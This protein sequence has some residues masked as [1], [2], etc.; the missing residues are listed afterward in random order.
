MQNLSDIT[1]VILAGGLGTRLQSIMHDRPKALAEVRGRAFL[2]YILD[3]IANIGV[4]SVV[5]CTGYMG[6]QVRSTFGDSYKRI[7]LIYS[8]ELSPLGTA[9]ALRFAM[10]LFKSNP[11]L[12]MNGDS[13]CLADLRLFWDWHHAKGAEASLLL[14]H[15]PDIQRY[16]QIQINEEN[17]VLRF[18]E[19]GLKSGQGWINAGIYIIA[20]SLIENIPT[21]CVV[22]LEQDMFPMWVG[23]GFYGYRS[24]A[25]FIDIGT[26]KSLSSAD[27]FFCGR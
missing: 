10:P 13:I 21:G 15:V 4:S 2:S 5:L 14:S 25:R 6:D 8:Q 18:S 19:K 1:V 3:Q 12:V 16:G 26:P 11:I 9:G 22:S 23:H 7:S 20:K 24:N 17:V 27:R